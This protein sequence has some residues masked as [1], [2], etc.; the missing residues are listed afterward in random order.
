[1]STRGSQF[2]KMVRTLKQDARTLKNVRQNVRQNLTVNIF[3][4]FDFKD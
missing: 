3:I 1:M 4:L 2:S